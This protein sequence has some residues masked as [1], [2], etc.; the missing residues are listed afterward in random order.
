VGRYLPSDKGRYQYAPGH[1]RTL[2][3]EA[4]SERGALDIVK[5]RCKAAGLPPDICN[6]SF[7]ATGI[8]LHQDAKGDMEAARQL[9]ASSGSFF[10][11]VFTFS[12]APDGGVQPPML[13]N[14]V[15]DPATTLNG[16][17]VTFDAYDVFV[18]MAGLTIPAQS[19]IVIDLTL[20]P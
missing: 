11:S 5:R 1:A 19:E 12:M 4:L 10:G 17:I 18:N 16:V 13:T 8:T 14:A 9:T 7:R 20:A 15:R 2:T 6:H 3:G